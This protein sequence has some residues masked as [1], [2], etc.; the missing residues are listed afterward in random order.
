MTAVMASGN[1]GRYSVAAMRHLLWSVILLVGCTGPAP[2]VSQPASGA[3]S[4]ANGAATAPW[5]R[6]YP[7]GISPPDVERHEFVMPDSHRGEQLY[8]TFC[9]TCHG[10][11]GRGQGRTAPFTRTPP[12]DLTR[13]EFKMRSTPP[14][15]LPT[16]GDVAG[17]IRNGLGGDGGMP[18]FAFLSFADVRA[19][20][21]KVKSFS[22]RWMLERAPAA[23]LPPANVETRA[24]TTRRDPAVPAPS[25]VESYWRAPLHGG[26][27]E[28]ASSSCAACHPQ[29][30]ADWSRSRH[31]LAMGPGIWAQMLESEP[32]GDCVRCHAPLTEQAKDSYLLAD[33]ISCA[34]CHVRAGRT[35]GPV[36][37]PGTLLPLVS[38]IQSAHG[39]V[40]TRSFF[41][42]PEFCA[43]CHHFPAGTAPMVAGTTLQNTNEEWRN[44][45]AA[46]EGR[47]CQTCH[48]PDRRHLF[49]GIHDPETVRRAVR[50]TFESDPRRSD[51]KARMTLTN[52]GAGHYLP[53]YVVPEI[54][55][56]IEVRNSAGV[57]VAFAEHRI[58]RK[59]T[60]VNGEWTQTSDTRLGPDET[61]TLEYTGPIPRDA[62]VITGRVFVLPDRWQ[63]DKFRAR[64]AEAQSDDVRKYYRAA[65]EETDAT[66]YTLFQSER[67]LDQ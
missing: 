39:P 32:G 15:S 7:A 28:L 44:S 59:V 11:D 9:M 17:V 10:A 57:T 45:R 42:Q 5:D 65:L 35:F 31:A 4:A 64:L 27:A 63:A 38:G 54:W 33:G 40:E 36:P 48:M 20:V 67:R 51:I 26:Q 29:Q 18:A 12:A 1:A 49:R 53:T 6:E 52:A 55:M 58:A 50:W 47:T 34:A 66:G 61:A 16:D 2:P 22:P 13:A 41:E 23:M 43:G 30:F 46:R 8:A 3:P 25:T 19:L 56:R 21:E 62:A 14:E 37:T 60:F 24:P